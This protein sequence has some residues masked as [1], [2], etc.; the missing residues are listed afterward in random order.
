ML[1]LVGCL[2][3]REEEKSQSVTKSNLFPLHVVE[4]LL[5]AHFRHERAREKQLEIL[6][7]ENSYLWLFLGEGF[8]SAPLGR[9][10]R[11]PLR[12][13]SSHGKFFSKRIWS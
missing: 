5:K 11:A 6:H 1:G 8:T 2:L 10:Q 3:K 4:G 12:F 9:M 13:I 7:P